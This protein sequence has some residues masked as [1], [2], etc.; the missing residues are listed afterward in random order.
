MITNI[1]DK[2]IN[3]IL[4]ALSKAIPQNQV[5]NR[6]SETADIWSKEVLNTSDIATVLGKSRKTVCRWCITRYKNIPMKKIG[7]SY[8][9]RAEE[10]KKWFSVA[11]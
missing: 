1:T 11:C 4:I 10:L 5:Q 7:S 9:G 6:N 3:E 8:Y 2:N